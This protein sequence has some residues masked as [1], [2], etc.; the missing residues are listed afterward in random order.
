MQGSCEKAGASH[1]N[2]AEAK[3]VIGY[4]SKLLEVT[5]DNARKLTQNDIGVVTPYSKQ[6]ELIRNKCAE[7]NLRNITIGT[8]EVFQGKEKPVMIVSTVRTY[9]EIGFVANPR[10]RSKFKI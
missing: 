3:A 4:I 10:V 2:R 8:S 6:A 7:N 9:G 5:V 1:I